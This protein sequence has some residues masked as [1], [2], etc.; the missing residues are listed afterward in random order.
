MLSCERAVV[1]LGSGWR[2]EDVGYSNSGMLLN[3]VESVFC[4]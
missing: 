1:G 4:E 2:F 3:W